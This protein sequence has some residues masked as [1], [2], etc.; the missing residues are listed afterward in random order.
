MIDIHSH[1]LWGLDDGARS[2]DESIAMLEMAGASGTTEI[3]AT[4]HSNAEYEYRPALIDERIQE[5]TARVSGG[6]R[7]RRGCDFHLDFD[8]ID[9]L[10]EDPSVYTIAGK[11]YL[12]VECPD[13]HVGPHTEA[14]LGRLIDA[15]LIPIVTH[16]ERN[17]V[18]QRELDRVEAWVESG[19][20]VQVTA[21]S[22][23]GGFGRGASA[24]CHRLLRR[25]LAH[26]VASDAHDPV[27]RNTRLDEARETVRARYGEEAAELL[28]TANPRA[29][30]NGSPVAGGRQPFGAPKRP[31]W[32]FWK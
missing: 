27:H 6:P 28:F 31:W 7:V 18:L 12:L 15:G 2:L 11:Q 29:I 21:L 20:L 8:N 1:I 3:V 17:P 22:V 4:P 19:C 24:A 30:V 32:R 23:T 10:L 25:G 26:V 16:P 9:R 5:L 14:V 13:L